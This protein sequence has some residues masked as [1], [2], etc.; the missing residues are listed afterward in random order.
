M[1]PPVWVPGQVLAASDVN[2][3]FLPVAVAKLAD[4]SRTNST[5]LVPDSELFV[6]VAASATYWF[7]LYLDYEGAAG[8]STG[9]IQWQLNIPSGGMRYHAIHE[10]PGGLAAVVET[11][12]GAGVL[13]G[14][15]LRGTIAISTTGGNVT[16]S[17][18][19]FAA[20]ATPTIVHAQ[21]AMMLQRIS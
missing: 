16:L 20:N 12:K 13:C 19:Q 3:W 8:A 2:S 18:G 7:Q 14:L 11:G 4:Q 21:S 10:T 15:S 5:T 6:T 17:W 9:G 1:P